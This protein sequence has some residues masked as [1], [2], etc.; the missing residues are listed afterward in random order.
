[1]GDYKIRF[2]VL[3]IILVSAIGFFQY[4]DFLDLKKEQLKEIEHKK[5]VEM[6]H[7]EMKNSI[8]QKEK[9]TAAIAL[10]LVHN[11]KQLK[12][13]VVQ[14]S[15]P[16]NYFHSYIEALKKDTNYQHI[17][18]QI[19]D[20]DM[21]SIYRSWD[22][23]HK[24]LQPLHRQDVQKVF[25]TKSVV[26]DVNVDQ[27]TLSLRALVPII[28]NGKVIAVFEV[29]S[30][31]NSIAKMLQEEN[32]KLVVLL[33]K[34]YKNILK[35]PYTNHFIDGYYIANFD[36]DKC[37]LKFLKGDVQRYLQQNYTIKN[38]CLITAYTI[39]S[40]QNKPL[41]YAFMFK[42]LRQ[43]SYEEFNF[44]IFKWMA[45]GVL[46]LLVTVMLFDVYLLKRLEKQ[47]LHY[48][49][50]I[51]L[52]TNIV[53]VLDTQKLLEVNR[54]FF[55]I[56]EKYT[57]IEE[58]H[59]D[60]HCISDFFAE[61]EGYV[62]KRMGEQSWLDYLI[63]HKKQQHK[64]KIVYDNRFYYFVISA[65]VMDANDKIYAVVL[66]DITEE[67]HY[68][69]ELEDKSLKDP[70]TNIANRRYFMEAFEHAI[71]VTKRC[72]QPLSLIMC[73]IDFF[74]NINDTHGHDIGDEVLITYTK[75]MQQHLREQDIFCRIGGEEFIIIL[76]VTGK[77][78]A[79]YVA[80]K[81]RELIANANEVVPVTM[82]FGVSEYEEGETSKSF[83][84]RVDLALYDAKKS[85]R[86]RVGVR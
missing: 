51:N 55:E 12:E 34:S 77:Q 11:D 68:K 23:T 52:S 71:N 81:L 50:I 39:Y 24:N 83:L 19:I 49:N 66:N 58:F 75:L 42:N 26:T 43:V 33:E 84:K 40:Q 41:A 7:C 8:E 61:E 67:E 46:T 2:I 38:G 13:F 82:S 22:D 32:I 21:R 5:L 60:H 27:Y 37:V 45:F 65:S 63:T 18:I 3:G 72:H 9:A 54:V 85:G 6:M 86:N 79:F 74:K 10:S 47:K 62:H 57:T 44:L 48:K 80:E 15:I 53:I 70:L 14:K 20:A 64:V 1:M 35:H 69:H 28:H 59:Q 78:E 4:V 25:E 17:W 76:P 73:D 30:H 16:K 56:F 31:F 29:I 36:V